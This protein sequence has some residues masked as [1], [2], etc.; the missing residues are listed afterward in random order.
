MARHYLEEVR[1]PEIISVN[2]ES[3]LEG[4]FIYLFIYFA[5]ACGTSLTRDQT[6][7]HYRR[8]VGS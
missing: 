2:T 8:S 5:V 3:S 6:H 7:A 4:D 1:H